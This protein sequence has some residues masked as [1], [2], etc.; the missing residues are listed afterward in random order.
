MTAREPANVDDARAQAAERLLQGAVGFLLPK[1]AH[2]SFP[3]E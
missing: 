3:W 1:H 2:A